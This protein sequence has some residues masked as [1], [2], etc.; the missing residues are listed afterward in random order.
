MVI[1]SDLATPAGVAAFAEEMRARALEPAFLVN[2]AGFGL[3][4]EAA[5]STA[6]ASSP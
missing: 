3:M 1:V 4:G 6:P 2:N 5:A